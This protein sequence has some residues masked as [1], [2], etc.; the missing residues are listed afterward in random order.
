MLCEIL[1]SEIVIY[2]QIVDWIGRLLVSWVV[3]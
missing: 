3:G 2:G 1:F